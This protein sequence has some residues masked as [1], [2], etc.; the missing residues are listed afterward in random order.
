[1]L[2]G[3]D[4][5]H[6]EIEREIIRKHQKYVIGLNNKSSN[7]TISGSTL[8]DSKPPLSSVKTKNY[9]SRINI[10]LNNIT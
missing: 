1:M 10:Q 5:D 3:M 2:K 7:R 8:P 4:I 9:S 6:K